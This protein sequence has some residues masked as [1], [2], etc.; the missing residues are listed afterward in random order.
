MKKLIYL[1]SPNK[2]YKNFY[3]DLQ[4]V[5]SFKN[6]TFFQLRLKKIKENK[7]IKIARKI[8][9]IT[10]KNKIKFI[11]N[12][13]LKI[14]KLINADGCH[15]GQ[16]DGSAELGRKY[17]KN[18]IIGVTCHNSISLAKIAIKNKVN[19]LAFGSFNKSHL[20]PKAKKADLDI[21]KWAKKI[22]KG[23]SSPLE[24]LII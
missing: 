1:I 24:A 7:I 16:K 20:K 22:L 2:I 9:K 19:Y 10:K 18:K 23:Q 4:K 14:A 5:L 8:Q 13:N 21:L 15:L 17:F 6:V 12:D 11:I 3:S